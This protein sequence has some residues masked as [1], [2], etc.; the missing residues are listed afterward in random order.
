MDLLSVVLHEL[1]HVVGLSDLDPRYEPHHLMAGYLQPGQQ[2]SLTTSA[3][4]SPAA[5]SQS[6]ATDLA[7][8]NFGDVMGDLL[9]RGLDPMTLEQRAE[10][11]SEDESVLSTRISSFDSR[12]ASVADETLALVLE[13]RSR[14][15]RWEHRIDD[16]TDSTDQTD[17]DTFDS[18]SQ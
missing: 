13:G 11:L 10:T 4:R 3:L 8:A 18:A 16:N 6:I 15:K 9:S 5:R 1:G 7:F 12:A 14:R 17:D 2:R